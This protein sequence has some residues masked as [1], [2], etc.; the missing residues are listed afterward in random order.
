[1]AAVPVKTAHCI[2]EIGAFEALDSGSCI[3]RTHA[4]SPAYRGVPCLLS[5]KCEPLV[6]RQVP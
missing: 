5:R 4:S 6:G 1:V 2:D 3:L